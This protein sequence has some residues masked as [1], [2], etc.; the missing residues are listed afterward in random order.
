MRN[1]HQKIAATNNNKMMTVL[2]A[3]RLWIS[4]HLDFD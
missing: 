4:I 1:D 3:W 2:T